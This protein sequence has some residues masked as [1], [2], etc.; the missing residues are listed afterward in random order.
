[1]M[2]CFYFSIV[3]KTIKKCKLGFYFLAWLLICIIKIK[4]LVQIPTILNMLSRS[5]TCPSYTYALRL[6]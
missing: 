3:L 6:L 2:K 4:V 1:M 5:D